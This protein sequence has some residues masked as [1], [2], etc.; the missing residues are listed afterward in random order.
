MKNIKKVMLLSLVLS[1]SS[2]M[3]GAAAKRTNFLK[4]NF[5]NLANGTNGEVYVDVEVGGTFGD[6]SKA[7]A[8]KTVTSDVRVLSC[9]S[10][11]RDVDVISDLDVRDG[12]FF[13]FVR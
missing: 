10:D 4:V 8:I 6:L 1:F 12:I 9:A 13:A 7:V 3:F 11:K 2:L 5:L